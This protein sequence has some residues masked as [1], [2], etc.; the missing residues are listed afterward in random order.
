[1]WPFG[2][3]KAYIWDAARVNLPGGKKSLAMSVYPVESQ[4]NDAW[5]R[6]TEYLKGIDR[7]FF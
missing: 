2:A 7:I 6:A 3:S 1:M 4:G 5:G